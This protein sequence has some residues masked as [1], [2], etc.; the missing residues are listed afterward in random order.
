MFGQNIHISKEN[1]NIT[2]LNVI[3][4]NK[5]IRLNVLSSNGLPKSN[6]SP[7]LPTSNSLPKY[8]ILP[9]FSNT[10]H[11]CYI[12]KSSVSENIY[13]G[14]TV[15]F[16]HRIR[17]H[18]GELVGGAKKTKKN[19]PWYPICIISGFYEAS[20]ALRFEFR[21]QKE[22]S[23]RNKNNK[24]MNAINALQKLVNSGD[25]SIIKNNKQAWPILT[26]SWDPSYS[27]LMITG[28]NNIYN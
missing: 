28:V 7:G 9:S 4:P 11:S 21:L 19:R 3:E 20:S 8:N 5:I 1:M 17:Q 2:R 24:T 26:I 23:K 6:I 13:I 15:D 25:G 22:L 14:Y 16:S 10:V 12:L 18:N 27:H